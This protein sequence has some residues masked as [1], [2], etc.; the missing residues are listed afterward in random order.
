MPP[1]LPPAPTPAWGS[2]GRFGGSEA[3]LGVGGV[4]AQRLVQGEALI[5]LHLWEPLGQLEGGAGQLGSCSAN[6]YTTSEETC[7]PPP[8]SR[9]SRGDT[10]DQAESCRPGQRTPRPPASGSCVALRTRGQ[11]GRWGW[12][13][14]GGC[15]SN[16]DRRTLSWPPWA[17]CTCECVRVCECIRGVCM[18]GRVHR[19]ARVYVGVCMCVHVSL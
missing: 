14:G 1:A 18:C 15:F 17:G 4:G 3:Q 2:A 13:Q 9:G 5:Q 6:I 16:R 7:L 10:S 11:V 12:T 8:G 19:C